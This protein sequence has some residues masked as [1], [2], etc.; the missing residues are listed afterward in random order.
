MSQVLSLIEEGTVPEGWGID[1]SYVVTYGL[2]C[3]IYHVGQEKGKSYAD[4]T[5]HFFTC[6]S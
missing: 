5:V 3:D 6:R 1:T 4:M 2:L